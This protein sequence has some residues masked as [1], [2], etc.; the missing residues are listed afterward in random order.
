[1]V[2]SGTSN[3]STMMSQITTPTIMPTLEI[4]PPPIKKLHYVWNGEVNTSVQAL[5]PAGC[6][7][8]VLIGNSVPLKNDQGATM[9]LSYRVRGGCWST[10]QQKSDH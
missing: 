1:M 5:M 6:K 9:C 3:Y 10:C 4:T 2:S 8:K 7:V